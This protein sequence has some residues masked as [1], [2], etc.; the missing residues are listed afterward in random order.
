MGDPPLE[1]SV[2]VLEG[3]GSVIGITSRSVVLPDVPIS[4]HYAFDECGWHSC[5]SHGEILGTSID[6][7]RFWRAHGPACEEGDT[8]TVRLHSNRDMSFAVN[9]VDKGVAFQIPCTEEGPFF[10]TVFLLSPNDSVQHL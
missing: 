1:H 3:S 7:S 4:K 5:V 10:C 8:V 9:G 6:G 2:R